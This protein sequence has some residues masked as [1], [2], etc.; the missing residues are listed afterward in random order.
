MLELVR[1][2]A[3]RVQAHAFAVYDLIKG[4]PSGYNRDL[5]EAKEPF[6][7]GIA[8]TRSTLR[9]LAGLVAGMKVNKAE[10]LAGFDAGVFATDRALELVGRGMPFRDAYH[11]VKQHLGELEQADPFE[12]IAKKTHLG[13][14]AGLDFNGMGKR[15]DEVLEF[16][17][18]ERD[19][20]HKA[21][22]R[23]LGTAYPFR[24]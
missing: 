21:V 4:L 8:V 10:L 7:E 15:V 3:S 23:L 22:S 5:Q 6:M 12:A 20:Y 13:A 19:S 16:V 14:T 24:A 1:A 11:H 17:A 2:K 18:D 9:I